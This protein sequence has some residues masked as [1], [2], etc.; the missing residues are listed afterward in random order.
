[1]KGNEKA[2]ELIKDI[3]RAESVLE[4]IHAY[5]VEYKAK[6]QPVLGRGKARGLSWRA[7]SPIIILRWKRVSSGF[8]SF[9]ETVF[10]GKDGIRSFSIK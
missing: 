10:Q 2:G 8:R 7:C 5:Y 1:M 6:D 9:L 3:E 4:K